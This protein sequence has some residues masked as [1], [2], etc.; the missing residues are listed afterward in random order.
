MARRSS[1]SSAAGQASARERGSAAAEAPDALRRRDPSEISD[2]ADSMNAEA[3]GA[4]SP[5]GDGGL[6][7]HP[8]HD[9][10]F[11]DI[12]TEEYESMV[13]E[14]ED[15]AVSQAKEGTHHLGEETGEAIIPLD[16]PLTEDE[17][18]ED[19]DEGDLIKK[20][21]SASEHA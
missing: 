18:V 15:S 7:D 11:D 2:L 8:V 17:L 19:E 13:D 16:A 4:A 12:E 1:S 5:P 14:V 20:D 6:L 10:D 9:Q 21:E 3:I